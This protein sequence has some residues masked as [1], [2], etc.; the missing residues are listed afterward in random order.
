MNAKSPSN[1]YYPAAVHDH[2]EAE[3]AALCQQAFFRD[4]MFRFLC[5]RREPRF[6]QQLLALFQRMQRIHRVNGGTSVAIRQNNSRGEISAIAQF[7]LPNSGFD[8]LQLLWQLTSIGMRC[9]IGCLQRFIQ[10]GQAMPSNWPR[11]PHVYLSVLAVA[12]QHQGKG[13]GA[14]LLDRVWEISQHN[15][16]SLGVCLDT[17]NPNNLSYYKRYGFNIIGE[18]QVEQLQS[19]CL[20]RGH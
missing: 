9:G 14:Y 20:Y 12:P 5:Q 16:D 8:S 13:Y 6:A 11:T 7:K 3:I 15:T 4:P 1:Q 10:I 18:C 17:Q 19:W 2:D